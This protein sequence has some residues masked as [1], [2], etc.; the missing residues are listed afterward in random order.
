MKRIALVEDNP[1]NR[2]LIQAILDGRYDVAEYETGAEALEGIRSRRPDLVL[3]DISLPGM[4]GREVLGH[5][6]A[7]PALN[8]VPVMALTAHV[9]SG[10]RG[11]MLREGFDEYMLKP[12]VDDEVLLDTIDRLIG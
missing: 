1:D 11:A 7:D 8:Q 3:L 6:R 2:L 5:I 4:D 9:V 12:I 10:G